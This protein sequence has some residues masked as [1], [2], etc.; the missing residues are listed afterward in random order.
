MNPTVSAEL[1]QHL[2]TVDLA[3]AAAAVKLVDILLEHAQRAAASDLHL[4]PTAEGLLVRLRLDGVLARVATLPRAIAPNVVARLKVLA[5]L[6]TYRS[7]TPQEGRLPARPDGI[8]VR[9]STM[10]TLH[11]E[12][13]IVRLFAQSGRFE[14][15][16][17]LGLPAEI[18]AALQLQ[19]LETSGMIVI[20]GPAGAGKTTTLYALLRKLAESSEIE[21]SLVS[22]EDP[23]E[24]AVQGVVQ[25]QLNPAAGLDLPAAVRAVVRHD[26]EVIAIGELRDRPSTEAALN[27]ALTGHLV[28]STFHAG[29]AAEVASRF[30]EMG[31]EPYVLRSV[32]RAVL[33]QRL[34]RRLCPCAR[35]TDDPAARMGLPVANAALP[36]GCAACRGTGYHGRIVLGELLLTQPGG[37]AN[38]ILQRHDSAA[39]E[40]AAL[41]AGMVSRWQ[42]AIRAVE[43][44]QTSPAEVRRALGLHG[45][46]LTVA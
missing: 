31:T 21:R 45:P 1:S 5:G 41:Q 12:R 33:H 37:V 43:S 14:R 36:V 28:L 8:E 11:G 35:P 23:I 4:D 9:V 16:E 38:A 40:Q 18:T 27:A 44:G 10:P 29:S 25:T 3:Q 17:N 34:V 20:A 22:L 19:L 15:L 2:Q 6:L 13:A 39:I 26:P 24:V 46:E 7:D 32:L 42:W 30:L